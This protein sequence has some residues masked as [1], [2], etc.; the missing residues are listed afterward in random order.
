MYQKI[1]VTICSFESLEQVLAY[2][3]RYG[4]TFKNLA[5]YISVPSN[6]SR[7]NL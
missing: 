4:T 3:E 5:L 7:E 2:E 1:A 6:E